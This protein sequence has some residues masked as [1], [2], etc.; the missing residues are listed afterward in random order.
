M[1]QQFHLQKLG[2]P[3]EAGSMAKRIVHSVYCKQN[4]SNYNG[5][6]FNYEKFLDS[7]LYNIIDDLNKIVSS[8]PEIANHNFNPLFLM[9]IFKS[10][11]N[12]R[13][14]YQPSQIQIPPPDNPY[15]SLRHNCLYRPCF[16]N[17]QRLYSS[18]H[19][20]YSTQFS[21]FPRPFPVPCATTLLYRYSHNP[22]A[23]SPTALV[24]LKLLLTSLQDVD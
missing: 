20:S 4:L 12:R 23:P 2:P 22:L 24:C 19:Y 17:L 18:S 8:L 15:Q 6:L 13:P 16:P 7:L 11:Y 1:T 5:A 10:P 9:N 14:Y 3:G 21:K